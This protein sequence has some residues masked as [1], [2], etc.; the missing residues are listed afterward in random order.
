M[1]SC[2]M[3]GTTATCPAGCAIICWDDCGHCVISCDHIVLPAKVEELLYADEVQFCANGLSSGA[4]ADTLDRL[5]GTSLIRMPSNLNEPVD[6]NEPIDV[7]F[8]GSMDGL[9]AHLGLER[10]GVQPPG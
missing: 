9:L 6:L 8:T 10:P 2:E 1:S 4:I 3:C 5:L 7:D